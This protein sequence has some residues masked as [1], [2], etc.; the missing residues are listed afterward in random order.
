MPK[1]WFAN[2]EEVF[3][4][5]D[6]DEQGSLATKVSVWTP[7]FLF[8]AAPGDA[9]IVGNAVDQR[10]IAYASAVSGFTSTL[11]V[12]FPT[13]EPR[14]F[15]LA[16]AVLADRRLLDAARELC[17]DGGWVLEPYLQ[18]ENALRV[19]AE[20]G[21]PGNPTHN[22]LIEEG[23]SQQLNDK[24]E[25]KR[26]AGH[27][28]IETIPGISANDLVG[29]RRAV[30]D[31][32]Q[33]HDGELMLRKAQSAGGVGNLCGAPDELLPRLENWYSNGTVLIE[34]K[35]ELL[36]TLGSLVDVERHGPE[37]I[38][39]DSQILE[40]GGWVGF[41]YPFTDQ[42]I[43]DQIHRESLAFGR[44][45]HQLGGRG[46][47]NLDWGIVRNDDG[48]RRAV[49]IECNFR[50][51]GFSHLIDLG[52]RLTGLN[53]GL[54]HA[55]FLATLPVRPE[56]GTFAGLHAAL[57]GKIGKRSASLLLEPGVSEAGAVIILPPEDGRAGI[58]IFAA[59][60]REAEA[61]DVAVRERIS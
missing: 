31:A 11:P 20:I 42:D 61:I 33:F 1:L 56:C 41:T 13:A 49:L 23:L 7:R 8:H 45:A 44:A 58:A 32:S 5:A 17:R 9:V 14:P 18:T 37:F 43:A 57:A 3:L 53:R 22:I 6:T 36:E 34:P 30:K 4:D 25:C 48:S 59:D 54:L 38:G 21:I 47:L 12:L 39:I 55:R 29:L 40:N 50:H 15:L 60:A 28:G 51:N 46:Y 16:E 52:A 35:L 26:I 27:L 19:A 24:L 2:I 10:F